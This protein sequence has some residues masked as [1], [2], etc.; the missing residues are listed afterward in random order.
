[1][2][3]RLAVLCCAVFLLAPPASAQTV[4]HGVAPALFSDMHWRMIGPTRAGRV[5]AVTGIA[6][7]PNRFYFGAVGGGV[8]RTDNAGRSWTPIFDDQPVASIGAVA[9]APSDPNTI[10]VGSGEADMRSDILQG[11]G[12]YKSTDAGKSWSRI[13]LA[14]SRAIGRIAVDPHDPRTLLVAALGHPYG[15]SHE[16]GIFRS[17]DGGATWCNTLFVD[18]NTGAIDV[19]LDPNDAKIVYATMWQTRRPPW[20][21]YP[22]SNGPG[23]GLYKSSDGGVTWTALRGNGFAT[24]A[25]GRIGVAVAPSDSKRVYAV[26]DAK[27]GGLYRSDDAGASWKKIDDETRIWGRG[28]YFSEVAVDPRER[29]IVYVSNT[30]VYRSNN[31]GTSFT[32]IKGAPGGDDYHMLWIDPTQGSR[33]ILASDQGAIV[34]LDN[35]KTWSSWYN[36]PTA[37]LYHV[38]TDSRF[39]FTV[40]GAQQDSGAIAVPSRSGRLGISALDWRPLQ[41]GG[42]SDYIAVDPR[43]PDTIYGGRVVKQNMRTR[44]VRD[45]TPTLTHPGASRDEWTLP[46]VFSTLDPRVLYYGNELLYRTADGGSSWQIISPDITRLDPGVPATL[47]APTAA[48]GPPNKRRGVIYTI[49][50]SPIK[51]GTIWIGTDDGVAALTHDEGKHWIV[52]TPSGL[53]PWSKFGIIEASHA[54]A[55]E[56]YAAVDRHRVDDVHPYIYRTRDGG[57]TWSTIATGIPD[58]SFVNAIREDPLKHGLLYAGTENGVYVSFDD[59]DAWQPLQLNLPN[60]SIRDLTVRDDALVIATHGRSFWILD[61]LTPLRQIDAA[62]VRE[63]AHLFAPQI[64]TRVQPKDDEGTPLPPDVAA[65]ENPPDGAIIDYYLGAP[66]MSLTIDVLDRSG[67]S[68]RRFSSDDKPELVDPTKLDIPAFYV[69]P[70]QPP[71]V[72]VGMHRFVWDLHHQSTAAGRRRRRGSGGPWAVPGAYRVRLTVDGKASEQPL[73]VRLDPRDRVALHDL[74]AQFALSSAIETLKG[75]L[76]EA[77][78]AIPDASNLRDPQNIRNLKLLAASQSLDELE[79]SIESAPAAPSLDQ[80]TAFA[81]RRAVAEAAL[82]ANAKP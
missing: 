16:R 65:G 30:S 67:A 61:D 1:M 15:P 42:E 10:Y 5:V 34:S 31:G 56:A 72:N 81:Q 46:L 2:I 24:Q 55:N 39:P 40:Y 36:Q 78:T 59:G 14:D 12:M 64:A 13:G 63:S 60:T 20:S 57:R 51:R 8:W 45:L 62:L 58:G 3:R 52:V 29:D 77:R 54:N 35:A 37:Q 71:A 27:D 21:V 70:A 41:A 44:E 82:R 66:A 75:R 25:L 53:A 17:T 6:G 32:A 68:I 26:V 23:S 50:P 73:I 38:A 43:D 79:A 76:A 48:D 47:D 19:T 28:W 11:N 4:T 69:H 74:Q 7:D 18:E 80:R 9:V 22:P 33:M 49:A